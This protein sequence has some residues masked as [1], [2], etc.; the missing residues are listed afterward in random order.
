MSVVEF[1]RA[2]RIEP[3]ITARADTRRVQILPPRAV[4]A[5]AL[6]EPVNPPRV[7]IATTNPNCAG[8]AV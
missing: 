8:W 3:I 2:T 7:K 6:N 4:T 5:L 1:D